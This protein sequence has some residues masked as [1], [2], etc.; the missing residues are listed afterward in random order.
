MIGPVRVLPAARRARLGKLAH[1]VEEQALRRGQADFSRAE[2]CEPPPTSDGNELV[3]CGARNGGRITR[4]PPGNGTPDAEW[5]IVVSSAVAGSRSGS[6]AGSRRASIV[7]PAPGR[8]D[9]QQMMATGGG[10][11]ERLGRAAVHARR[12]C[13]AVRP[14]R[15][16]AI[17]GAD[18]SYS[19]HDAAPVSAS[20]SRSSLSIGRSR[21]RP[22]MRASDSASAGTTQSSSGKTPTIGAMPGTR[23]IDPSRP[24][25]PTNARPRTASTGITSSATN[26]PIAIGRSRPEPVLRYDG[27]ARLT[28][29]F[30]SDQPKPD[31]MIAARTRSRASRHDSSG[32]PSIVN[33]GMP[34][35]TWTSTLTGCPR[36]PRIVAERIVA[37]ILVSRKAGPTQQRGSCSGGSAAAPRQWTAPYRGGVALPP[38][39][40]PVNATL[41]GM[42]RPPRGPAA[43]VTISPPWR[44]R[45]WCPWRDAATTACRAT[46][47]ASAARR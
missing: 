12:P 20:T 8:P 29:I 19:G 37:I 40:A 24:S 27:G 16:R 11:L 28:V 35:A 23:R 36:A 45:R 34:L 9:E 7:L 17:V 42:L 18:S 15:R 33:P 46:P 3:W 10:R 5:I 6:S 21:P 43:T 31:V 44:W 39:P 2:A 30:L 38:L 13:R 1:L 14:R 22:T 47:S 4:P 25:S 41:V 26:S 32:R